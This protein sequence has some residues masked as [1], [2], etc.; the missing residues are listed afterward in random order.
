MRDMLKQKVSIDHLKRKAYLY[1]RQSSLRQLVDNQ[2]STKRQYALKQRAVAL[3]WPP[4]TIEVIDEDL[5]QSGAW[6]GRSGFQRLVGE[7][8]MGHAGIV[9]SLEVSRLARNCSDWHRLLEICSV[10]DTLI[11]DEEGIYN[12][13]YFNDRLL[14]GLKGTMSEAELHVIRARLIGGMLNKAS[15][16]ELKLR[17][18]VGFVYDLKERVVLDPDKQIQGIIRHLFST[19]RRVGTVFRTVRTFHEEGIKFPN[20]MHHGPSKGDVV[21]TSLKVSR[22]NHILHNPRYAGAYVY[23]RRTQKRKDAQ[24]RPIVSDLPRDEWH[25]LIKDVHEG[26]ISWE[27]YEENQKR[28]KANSHNRSTS[29]RSVPREGRALLQGLVICGIC[30]K[31]MSVRY[32]KTRGRLRPEYACKGH[33]DNVAGPRC[34]SMPGDGIDEAVGTLLIETMNPVALDVALAVQEE[35]NRRTKEADRIRQ[36]HV[37]RTRYEVELARRRYLRVD[38]DNRLVADAL[39]ADWNQNLRALAEAE[40]QYKRL[41]K[42]DSKVLDEYMQEKIRELASNFPRLWNDPG[43]PQRE[44]KRMTNLLLEDVTLVKNKEDITAHIRFKG[45]T[46]RTLHVPRPLASWQEWSTDSKVVAEIDRLLEH[47]TNCQVASILNESGF[48]S[49]KGKPFHGNRISKTWRA[50]GLKSRYERLRDKGMLTRKELAGKQNVHQGTIT[51]WRI[52]GRVKGH[53]ADDQGQ[54]LFED[55]GNICLRLKK[56]NDKKSSSKRLLSTNASCEAKEAQYE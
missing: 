18:P 56:K 39:E 47:H 14:L 29:E 46:A 3:G 36:E 17:L 55:P 34:Q 20:R 35:L 9:L 37:E 52:I 25:A 4:E 53:L 27:E 44:R 42:Q 6:S 43:T 31:R 51:K 50:Y 16:G 22:V 30:G 23:G 11:L 12:P 32:R 49:G 15:R 33:G 45:G 40:E 54:Y 26:Y 24:G 1:V 7:V 21:W 38:P 19:F 2:E 8:G 10:S 5:G 13:S 41:R 28:L 48:T